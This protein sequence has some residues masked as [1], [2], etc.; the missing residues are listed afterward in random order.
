MFTAVILNN[1]HNFHLKINALYLNEMSHNK[2][3][4]SL[5]SEFLDTY[6]DEVKIPCSTNIVGYRWLCL[7][8]KEKDKIKV[9]DGETGRSSRLRG[10]EHLK[11]LEKK[12]DKSVLYKHKMSDHPHEYVKFKMEITNK[13]K[14]ALTRQANEAVRI[15][16]RPSHETLNSKS[17]FKKLK[18]RNLA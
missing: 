13:F 8:C 10:S 4:H 9:Y 3:T 18:R 15:F 16:S 14:D 6:S 5:K 2:F 11:D 7:T 17:E 1:G 12:R